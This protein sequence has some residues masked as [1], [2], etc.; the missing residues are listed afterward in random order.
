MSSLAFHFFSGLRTRGGEYNCKGRTDERLAKSSQNDHMVDIVRMS[1]GWGLVGP[2]R[3]GYTGA[4]PILILDRSGRAGP[5]VARHQIARLVGWLIDIRRQCDSHVP[6]P[7]MLL[8]KREE[9]S[10]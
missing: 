5:H 4:C 2:S 7:E 8:Y 3:P 9:E 10:F 1:G 6:F